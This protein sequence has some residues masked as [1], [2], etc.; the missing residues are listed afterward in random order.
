MI[1]MLVWSPMRL[2][3]LYTGHGW[4]RMLVLVLF[5][6]LVWRSRFLQILLVLSMHIRCGLFFVSVMS[7]L[8]SL[9]ILLLYVRG[10]STVDDF[11]AQMSAV[12][13]QLDSIGPPLS[14]STCDSCKAQKVALETRRTY[15]LLSSFELSWFLVCPVFL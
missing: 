2:S 1:I 8:V 10:D 14:P 5:L 13:R 4:M 3:L 6:L 11:Y 7:L 12:W 15:D 9:P